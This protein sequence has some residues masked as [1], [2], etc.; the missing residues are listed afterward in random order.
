MPMMLVFAFGFSRDHK[1]SNMNT[2]LPAKKGRPALG[3]ISGSG[4][5]ANI[6]S[7]TIH[8]K[9]AVRPANVCCSRKTPYRAL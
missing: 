9:S 1:Y 3:A 5:S 4:R 7:I 8:T 2:R 6:P